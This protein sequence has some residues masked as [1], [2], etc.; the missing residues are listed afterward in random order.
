MAGSHNTVAKASPYGTS[1]ASLVSAIQ[2]LAPNQL[3][4]Q[5]LF[6]GSSGESNMNPLSASPGAL[7][8][9]GQFTGSGGYGAFG[10]TS[11]EYTSPGGADYVPP[12]ASAAAQVKAILPSYEA[13]AAQG[14]PSGVTGAAAAELVALRGENPHGPP[15][16]PTSAG[17]QADIIAT[18]QP[19]TYGEN[20]S[21]TVQNWQQILGLSQGGTLPSG[22]TSVNAATAGGGSI[23]NP[24]GTGSSPSTTTASPSSSTGS[25]GSK[26]GGFL[27]GGALLLVGVIILFGHSASQAPPVEKDAVAAA[28]A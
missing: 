23:T 28:A 26:I 7:N 21:Y 25:L 6:V 11:S 2:Q 13:A 24:V 4:E 9:A 10:F 16:V 27:L 17:E 22:P 12:G 18:N 8:S 19:T 3:V 20:T 15:G 5:A 1:T 14:V